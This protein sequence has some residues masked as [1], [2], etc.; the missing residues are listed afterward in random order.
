L[1]KPVADG[2]EVHTL[3]QARVAAVTEQ[4]AFGPRGL[5]LGRRSPKTV[6]H[7]VAMGLGSCKPVYSV[8]MSVDGSFRPSSLIGWLARSDAPRPVG[9][10]K[11]RR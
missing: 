7:F 8:V 2:D 4:I 10:S 1:A 6:K 5:T 3:S 11:C 9:R